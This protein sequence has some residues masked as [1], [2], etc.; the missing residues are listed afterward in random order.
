MFS[1]LGP[2]YPLLGFGFHFPVLLPYTVA[3]ISQIRTTA[4]ISFIATGA[5]NK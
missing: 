1:S 3:E 5:Q 2:L 4:E